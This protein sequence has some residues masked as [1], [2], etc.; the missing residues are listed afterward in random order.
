MCNL[1]LRKQKKVHSK[2]CMEL[3]PVPT[4]ALVVEA[5]TREAGRATTPALI[6]LETNIS[7]PKGSEHFSASQLLRP[8]SGS[9]G[10]PG[11]RS[12]RQ[13]AALRSTNG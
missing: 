9:P 11:A 12:L 10:L 2:P 3:L 7:S 8:P 5:S 4:P 13:Q 6:S 1:E